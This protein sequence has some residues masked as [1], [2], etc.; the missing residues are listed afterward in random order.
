MALTVTP[1]GPVGA[2]ITGLDVRAA[3]PP[4]AAAALK[5]AFLKHHVL[6]V[7]DQVLNEAQQVAFAGAFGTVEHAR[8]Q[9]V[10]AERPETMIISNIRIDGKD[11]GRLPDGE[12]QWHFDKMYYPEPNMAAVGALGLTVRKS[13]RVAA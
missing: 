1:L 4:E 7:R 10:I 8:E 9:S 2:Q 11:V 6:I 3:I 13:L 5:A 12:V